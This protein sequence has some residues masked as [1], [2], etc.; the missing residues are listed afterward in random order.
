MSKADKSKLL[1]GISEYCEA[2]SSVSYSMQ[3]QKTIQKVEYN[4]L[5]N[6]SSFD[7]QR[8]NPAYNQLEIEFLSIRKE[9]HQSQK[10]NY[11]NKM[12]HH[13]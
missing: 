6:S 2:K 12:L 8:L 1:Q 5:W 13:S 11:L 3:R 7:L 10:P 9:L 4:S